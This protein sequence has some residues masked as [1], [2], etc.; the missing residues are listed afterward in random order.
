M[1]FRQP[2]QRGLPQHYAPIRLLSD[3]TARREAD[4]ATQV[5]V[6]TADTRSNDELAQGEADLTVTAAKLPEILCESLNV[7]ILSGR[8][9][10]VFDE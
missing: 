7:A 10:F 9:A 8:V 4:P 3:W 6:S 1:P 2:R 5:L